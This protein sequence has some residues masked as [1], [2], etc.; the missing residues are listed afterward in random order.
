M[1][2]RMS[3][4]E[5]RALMAGREAKLCV[6]SG[7]ISLSPAG[8]I[9]PFRGDREETTQKPN[10]Y[11]NHKVEVD[12]MKFDS[13]HEADVYQ[14]LM[15]RVKAGELR[16]VLRQIPFPLPGGIRYIADFVTIAPDMR[17]EGVYD[18]KSPITKKDRV[19]INKKKQMKAVWDIEIREV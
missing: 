13:Q 16:I 6:V 8:D 11:R 2:L 9:S 3:D 18:A 12:G 1:A 4:E 19:Y 10:K 15:L 5:F 17:I 7:K 14:E